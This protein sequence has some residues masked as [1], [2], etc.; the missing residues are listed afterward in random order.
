MSGVYLLAVVGVWIALTRFLWKVGQR[1][2]NAAVPRRRLRTAIVVIAAM[3]WLG[4]SFWFA[5]GRTMYYD[6][7]VNRMCRVDGGVKVYER[8]VLPAER[9]DKWG[10]ARIPS[11]TEAT[12]SDEYY[13]KSILTYYMKGNPEIWRLSF[14]VY[15]RNDKK[16][17]GEAVSYGRRGG[18]FPGPWH[19]SSFGCPSHA[20]IAD[21]KKQL[22]AR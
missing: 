17:I 2:R 22:F 13:Y 1:F 14:F 16:A 21:L 7:M 12:Q 15:R 6:T 20:D 5:G 19:E 10:V 9:F 18:N 3:L 11:A 4:L 8:V